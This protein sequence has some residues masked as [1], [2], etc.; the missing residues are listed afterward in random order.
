MELRSAIGLVRD[1]AHLP[2][3]DFTDTTLAGVVAKAVHVIELRQALDAARATIGASALTYTDATLTP[4]VSPFKSQ[5]LIDL[6][7]GLQ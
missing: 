5:H 3:F 6:R 7:N 2:A 1:L 4:H